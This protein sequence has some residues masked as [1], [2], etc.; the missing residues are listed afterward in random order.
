MD[1]WYIEGYLGNQKTLNR[2]PLNLFPFLIGRQEGLSL[3]IHSDKVSRTHAE[4]NLVG[5]RLILKDKGSA[6]GTFV[7]RE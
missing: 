5:N 3:T 6:N 4:I 7:N 2:L 1:N